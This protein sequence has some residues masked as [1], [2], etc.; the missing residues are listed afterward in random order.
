MPTSVAR[1]LVLYTHYTGVF[2]IAAQ[3]AWA[4]WAGRERLRQVALANAAVAVAYLA[5]VPSFFNQREN[6]GIGA[7]ESSPRR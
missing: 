1:A 3:A 5:W 7:I 2:A 4:F 6:K